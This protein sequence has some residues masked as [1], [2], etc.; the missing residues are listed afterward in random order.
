M[1]AVKLKVKAKK[2]VKKEPEETPVEPT[3]QPS[4]Q[5]EPAEVKKPINSSSD[6]VV[7]T[8]KKISSAPESSG[9][10][11]DTKSSERKK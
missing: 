6:K 2:I 11:T 8:A 1:G 4:A 3:S 7:F 5:T 9:S 10:P